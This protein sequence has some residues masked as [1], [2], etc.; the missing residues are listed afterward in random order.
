MV[1]GLLRPEVYCGEDV[2]ALLSPREQRA[3]LLHE[4]CHQRRRDPVRLVLLDAVDQ[5]LGWLPMV[6][7][8]TI[9]QR[10]RIEIRADQHALRGG[11]T[12]QEIAAALLRL[13]SSGL[14]PGAG[15]AG[16]TQRRLEALLADESPISHRSSMRTLVLPT[17]GE[18]DRGTYL[19]SY[20]KSSATALASSGPATQHRRKSSES[21]GNACALRR[22]SAAWARI[23]SCSAS[24]GSSLPAAL[25]RAWPDSASSSSSRCPA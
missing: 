24:N 6:R 7:R 2:H 21:T 3:V 4:R 18:L 23:P 22:H 25:S 10:A 20:S 11:A 16:V 8:W 17:V 12:R 19:P 14:A 15:F 13:G 9:D 5:T 1:A